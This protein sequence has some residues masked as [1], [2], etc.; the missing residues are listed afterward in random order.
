MHFD[1]L[2]LVSSRNIKVVVRNPHLLERVLWLSSRHMALFHEVVKW[3]NQVLA[4][5]K[6]IVIHLCWQNQTARP[7]TVVVQIFGV[8]KWNQLVLHPVD[9]ES[10]G[11]Y[12]LYFFNVVEPVLN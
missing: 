4:E 8:L 6:I 3:S 7:S 5:V 1:L 12:F 10:W 9:D 11:R 2:L